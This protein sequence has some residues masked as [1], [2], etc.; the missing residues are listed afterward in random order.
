MWRSAAAALS[1]MVTV[2][3][4]S[5]LWYDDRDIAFLREDQRDQAEI[6]GVESRSI[7]TLVDA[8]YEPESVKAAIKAQDWDLLTHSGLYSVQ[9]QPPGT[10][11]QAP[12][13]LTDPTQGD[14]NGNA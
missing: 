4:G 10:A 3:K 7:R 2:P 8:G 5:R 11:G 1:P 9:L 14:G 12:A 6:Q 13:D